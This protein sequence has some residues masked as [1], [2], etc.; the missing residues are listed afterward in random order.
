MTR[1]IS[2]CVYCTPEPQGSVRAFTPKGWKRPVLTSDNKDLKSFRQEVSKAAMNARTAAGFGDLVFMK[3]EPVEVSFTFYFA[4]PPSV[5]K[6][7]TC[8][9]VK[10]DLSKL[11]RAAEDSLTGIIFNDDAQVININ[12][13]KD[14]GL[15][16]R[17]EL[18]VREY[19]ASVPEL[20]ARAIGAS[21]VR[22]AARI[23][24][25]DNNF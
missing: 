19:A 1:R 24:E 21:P 20:L 12:A 5:P 9:V 13:R 2:L 16:E 18:E 22:A 23:P 7:R 17:V 15:P 14:Y 4:R 25:A 8:H 6:K 11:V 3:H 10:P